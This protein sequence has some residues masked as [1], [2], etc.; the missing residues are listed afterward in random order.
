KFVICDLYILTGFE[1][2]VARGV[3]WS[4]VSAL[5]SSVRRPDITFY[6]SA[7]PL[8]LAARITASREIKF[9]EAGQDVTA[10]ENPLESYLCFAPKVIE[11][12][13]KLHRE[14]GFVV[15]DAEQSIYDQHRLIRKIYEEYL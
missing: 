13:A 15:L 1:R 10:V 3:S 12:Y 9:Y 2:V 11:E 8:T 14:F 4:R 6:F 7:P 5:Y